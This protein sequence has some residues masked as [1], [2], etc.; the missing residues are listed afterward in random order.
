MFSRRGVLGGLLVGL[1]AP[2]VVR[3]SSLMPV[4]A[5]PI[6]VPPSPWGGLRYRL[7]SVVSLGEK[8]FICVD[9]GRQDFVP[10]EVEAENARRGQS[11]W[12]V[13]KREEFT[14][15]RQEIWDRIN[16]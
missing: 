5:P 7:G 16:G 14:P 4:K 1:F 3:A 10:I 8:F 13:H 9:E 2:A 12:H 15:R 11:L 6:I